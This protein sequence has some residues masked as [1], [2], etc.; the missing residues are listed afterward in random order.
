MCVAKDATTGGCS[1]TYT[2]SRSLLP[3]SII[4][5][6]SNFIKIDKFETCTD[7]TIPVNNTNI[8]LV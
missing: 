5:E 1:G 3:F 2:G 8:D 6:G 7:L 4:A